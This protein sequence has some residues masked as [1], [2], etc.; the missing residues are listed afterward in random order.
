MDAESEDLF[1]NG[2]A[3]DPPAGVDPNFIN[4]S[5]LKIENLAVVTLC[6]VASTLVVAMRMWTKTRL[7]R[8]VVLDDCSFPPLGINPLEFLSLTFAGVCCLA[9]VRC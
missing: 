3:M 1:L 7:V 2:P 5:N 6:L 8:K 4:P 9:Q